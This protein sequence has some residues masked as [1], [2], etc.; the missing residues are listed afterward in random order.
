MWAISGSG[1]FW[2]ALMLVPW[3]VV[4]AWHAGGSWSVRRMLRS[5]TGA[6]ALPRGARRRR[7]VA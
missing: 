6:Q 2:P 4:L 5:R 7:L 1:E 3:L